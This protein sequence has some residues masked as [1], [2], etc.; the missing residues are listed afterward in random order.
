MVG[1]E[2]EAFERVRPLF[3]LMGKN[4]VLQGGA[5]SGQYTKMCNQIAIASGMVAICESMAY[6]KAAGLDPSTVLKSIESGA[7]GSWSLSNLAPRLLKGDFDPGFYIKHFIKDMK[8]AIESA[9]QMQ[10]K[11]PGL[12]L[13]K[14]LYDKLAE[15]GMGDFGTQ[16]LFQMYQAE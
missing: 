3:D 2:A 12:T 8:I 15:N 7:A 16:A 6:A 13:A 1:G 11:L 10:L 4:I 9:E 5:G 14:T